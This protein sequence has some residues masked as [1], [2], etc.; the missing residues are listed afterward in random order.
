MSN[1]LAAAE[2]K[3]KS[4][5][6]DDLKGSSIFLNRI[7]DNPEAARYFLMYGDWGKFSPDSIFAECDA[8]TA[9]HTQV[10]V[11]F[12]FCPTVCNFCAFYPV[13]AKDYETKAA[14]V[15]SLKKEVGLLRRFYFDKGFSAESL[16]LGGGTPT[17]LPLDLLQ[18]AVTTILEKIPFKE[19]EKNFETTPEAIVGDDGM[20][21][22]KFLKQAGFDRISIGAQSFSDQVLKTANRSHGSGHTYQALENARS[23][24][25]DRVNFDLLLGLLDQTTDDFIDSVEKSIKLEIDIIEIYTMRYFDTKK[26]VPLTATF[27]KQP[28]RFLTEHDQLVAR[29]AADILLREAGYTS[30]NGR[31][32]HKPVSGDDY[33]SEYYRENF[34]GSNILGIG[35]KSHSNI[36][37]WQYANYRNI[38]KYSAALD[39]DALPIAVGHKI[40]ARE[41]FAK[42]LT[43]ALQLA[44]DLDYDAIRRKSGTLADEPLDGVMESFVSH[45]LMTKESGAYRKT[46][47]GFLFIEEML[48]CVY[49]A[50]VTPFS[51]ETEFLGK[52]QDSERLVK[53]QGRA[54]AA[55]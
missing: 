23:V 1:L 46:F 47:T 4:L 31:T 41:M 26:S 28:H 50:A 3:L 9:E 11:D 17:Y 22:L 13:I 27:L 14:Y 37:P 52:A 7:K 30:S 53:L 38:D 49:D 10:Y 45:G 39:G 18:D 54:P 48:K 8:E 6:L 40:N 55:T 33:Y 25:F 36:Y 5:P 20:A 35:R 16:E 44:D 43:G 24:G 2:E 15:E 12:P 51:I 29:T 34:K 32:Y 42:R 21:K 19:G